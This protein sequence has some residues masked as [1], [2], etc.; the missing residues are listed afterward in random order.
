MWLG[1]DVPPRM[2]AVRDAIRD[3]ATGA[4]LP[5]VDPIADRWFI[6]TDEDGIA[7]T[8]IDLNDKGCQRLAQLVDDA[9]QR[10]GA[11]PDRAGPVASRA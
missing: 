5:F 3:A 11:L 6:G 7:A 2:L 4:S 10:S 1:S 8:R 9:V